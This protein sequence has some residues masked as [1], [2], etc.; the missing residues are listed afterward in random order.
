MRPPLIPR[1]SN[2][3]LGTDWSRP[4][5]GLPVIQPRSVAEP[6]RIAAN[7]SNC[8]ADARN[9]PPSPLC[10]GQLQV[11]ERRREIRPAPSPRRSYPARRGG[12]VNIR[13][14]IFLPL[15]GIPSHAP[16]CVPSISSCITTRSPSL[17]ICSMLKWRS[18]KLAI[19]LVT[20]SLI[21]SG[22]RGAASAWHARPQLMCYTILGEDRVRHVEPAF[23]PQLLHKPIDQ[24]CRIIHRAHS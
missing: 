15:A 16:W 19:Q 17:N 4:T 24:L 10:S 21:A 18:G 2:W 11:G 7:I 14:C 5:S 8:F 3:T 12:R 1:W 9:C 6:S 20:C 13:L 22:P 23:I